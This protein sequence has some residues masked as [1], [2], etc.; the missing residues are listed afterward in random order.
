MKDI[1]QIWNLAIKY[2]REHKVLSDLLIKLA[3]QDSTP[4]RLEDNKLIIKVPTFI[5]QD[6]WNKKIND[7]FSMA[8]FNTSDMEIIPVPMTEEELEENASGIQQ[9]MPFFT[10]EEEAVPVLVPTQKITSNLNASYIFDNFVQG[11]SNRMASAASIAVAEKPGTLYN[12]LFVYG[13]VGLGKTHLMQAIGHA[14][15]EENPNAR[16]KY[17]TAENFMNDYVDAIK[18]NA[19]DAFRAQYRNLDMLLVDDIQFL[20]RK[21]ETQGEFFHTFEALTTQNKQIVITCDRLPKELDQLE[22]RLVSRFVK[23]LSVKIDTAEFETRLAILRKK[24]ESDKLSIPTEVLELIAGQITDNIRELQGGITRVL[25]YSNMEGV[26]IT[27]ETA[28]LALAGLKTATTIK[29]ETNVAIIQDEVAKYYGITVKDLKGKRRIKA[30]S[31]PRQIAMYLCRELTDSSL[32][33][34]GAEFG[35]KDHT[36]VIYAHKQ[37]AKKLTTD[38]K[39]QEEIREIKGRLS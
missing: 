8:V 29:A 12:P 37:T 38:Q 39:L 36:S 9:E 18:N 33:Y 26:D 7:Y 10:I 25:F 1:T 27:V 4:V 3:D 2:L 23:G 31:T 19:M 21:G 14:F 6:L 30:I 32:P 17:V 11:Q 20:N 13:G 34:I 28:S 15:L 16:I 22:D 24:A 35:G 5:Q